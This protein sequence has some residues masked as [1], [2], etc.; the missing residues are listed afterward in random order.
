MY[1]KNIT[2]KNTGPIRNAC[3]ELPFESDRPLPLALVGPNGS[4]KSTFISFIANALLGLK[5]FVYEDTEIEKG[6]VYRVRKPLGIH[7][8][9]DF[10][11]ARLNFD[12]SV[13]LV[14][15]QLN[16]EKSEYPDP[17]PF[18]QLDD[19]WNLIPANSAD[20]FDLKLGSLSQPYVLEKE[21]EKFSLLFFPA[22]RFEPPDWLNS[23]ALSSELRID[24]PTLLKGKTQRRILSRNRLR[25]T[26]DWFYSVIFDVFVLEYESKVFDIGT[27]GVR[28]NA[29]V[30]S[31]GRANIVFSS[32]LSVLKEVICRHQT[33]RIEIQFS[34][35]RSRIISALVYS[36]DGTL[37]RHIKDLLSLSAGESALFCLFA[38]IIRDAD[39]SQQDFSGTADIP[40]IVL[41]DEADMHLHLNLQYYAFPNLLAL[42]PKIQFILSFHAPMI[43]LGLEKALGAD[44]FVIRE[45]PNADIITPENYSEFLTAYN[46]YSLSSKFE[47][48]LLIR[49]SATSLPIILVEG[50]TD[51]SLIVTAWEK[52]Y[53]GVSIPYEIIPCGLEPNPDDRSG[54]AEMLRRCCEFLSIVSDR[55]VITVFDNDRIGN[56]QFKGVSSKA[57]RIG[58]DDL[59][60]VHKTKPMHSILLPIPP[61][62]EMF[63]NSPNMN[64]RHL[65]IE[66]YFEDQILTNHNLKGTP[67]AADSI[68][69]EI[70]GTSRAKVAFSEASKNFAPS[71]FSQFQT[72]FDRISY[73]QS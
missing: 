61:G 14:E 71:E 26:L 70:E 58:K 23:Q 34:D 4:G 62:R 68:V 43:A 24:V 28:V 30:L 65:S 22:D 56:E 16:R 69:F 33:D 45:L 44:G 42:F 9:S 59:H 27:T 63:A 5:Q 11:F 6:Q 1:L 21:L 67:V 17:V 19:T 50:K 39:L 49:L 12:M 7:F 47:S 46:I 55:I 72:L 10:Y 25:P 35:R 37:V 18:V 48:D 66:H 51:V 54:G 60:K 36:Q 20:Y 3:F 73:I 64:F 31:G 32:I 40:G 57:F 52:L 15:W 8:E 53:P 2:L 38:S 41:I 13:S 29:R